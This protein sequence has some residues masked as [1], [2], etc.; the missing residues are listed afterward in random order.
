MGG[1]WLERM[2]R[3]LFVILLVI[4][5]A[6]G[7]YF[8]FTLAYPFLIA[9]FV[10]FLIQPLV[11]FFHKKISLPRG[12]AAFIS[13][14]L[15][16]GVISGFMTVIVHELIAG[17]VFLTKI[18]PEKIDI[19]LQAARHFFLSRLMPLYD[20]TLE[21]LNELDPDRRRTITENV[22]KI[23]ANIGET[24]AQFGKAILQGL[25][26][27]VAA[28]PNFLTGFIFFLLATFFISKDWHRYAQS[29]RRLL[30]GKA[31]A[32]LSGVHVELKKALY[33]FVKAQATLISITA[34][35]IFIGLLILRIDHAL[36]IALII[37]LIDLFPYVGTGLVFIP[38][39]LYQFIMQNYFLTI[40]L[41]VLYAVVLITRQLIEPKIISSN[42][43]LDP[44][45]T[46]VAIFIGFQLFGFFGLFIGP[47]ILVI[48]KTLH[49]TGLF[50]EIGDFVIG[51]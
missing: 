5:V 6:G 26:S 15:V 13:F 8:V 28:L 30:P 35:I 29:I 37:G 27:F 18:L 41:A 39:I 20:Q 33:G 45:S 44:L 31:S 22:E 48:I 40:G 19:L 2:L 9:L 36:S 1:V 43:G 38:W 42:I 10:A 12:L 34:I 4:A 46:L 32:M 51:R 24:L 23:G 3:L 21:L 14:L 50:R 11:Q 47:V 49:R 7:L 16:L 25:S 17:I